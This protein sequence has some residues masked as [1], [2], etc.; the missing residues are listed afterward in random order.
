MLVGMFLYSQIYLIRYF[1]GIILQPVYGLLSFKVSFTNL[2][3]RQA[4]IITKIFLVT[5]D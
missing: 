5:K 3:K 4:M 2:H 1:L